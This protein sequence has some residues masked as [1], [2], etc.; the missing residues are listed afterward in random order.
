MA[1]PARSPLGLRRLFS[2]P[3]AIFAGNATAARAQTAT[4]PAP[5]P[6]AASLSASVT[7]SY[8]NQYM[9]R[10]ERLAGPSFQPEAD[11]SFGNCAIGL[12][13]SYPLAD[14]DALQADPELDFY[15][16]YDFPI[17][18]RVSITP[19]FALYDYPN[20]AT[21]AGFFRSTFEPSLAVNYTLDG[22]KFTPKFYYDVVYRGP[23]Y[24]LNVT[25]ALPLKTL[26]TELDFTGSVGS[27]DLRNLINGANPPVRYWDNYWLVGVA[28]PFS[29]GRHSKLTLGIAYTRGTD[30]YVK[31]GAP[32]KQPDPLAAG[33]GVET[34][35]YIYTF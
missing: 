21:S 19:G 25:Y 32:P 12:W 5:A 31:E 29:I 18:D 9:F 28:A 33:R 10:G 23:T 20:A 3:L 13:A 6:E 22:V 14:K 35:S 11:L 15:G 17:N 24:E 27:V 26:G 8:V 1:R 7:A 16:S 2:L 30:A 4:A 34:I